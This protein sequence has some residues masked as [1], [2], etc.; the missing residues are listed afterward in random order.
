M[1]GPVTSR[2]VLFYVQHLLGIGHLARASRS[3]TFPAGFMLVAA[4]NPCPCGYLGHPRRACRCRPGEAER[5]TARVSGPLLDRID[6]VV[7]V[8]PV[9]PA[10]L[11]GTLQPAEGSATV[12]ARVLAARDRQAARQGTV[13]SRLCGGP[14]DRLRRLPGTAPLLASAMTRLDLSARAADRLLRVAR[15]VADLEGA[16]EVDRRH[17]AEA[18]QFRPC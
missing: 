11:T 15:T 2:R 6:L 12:R 4:M 9:D 1:N 14:L 16:D 13:N 3:V 17:L 8:P 18:L 7:Q 10:A 5:Y